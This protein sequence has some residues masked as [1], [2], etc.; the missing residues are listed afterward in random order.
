MAALF[1]VGAA[2]T[3]SVVIRQTLVQ[4]HTPD[5]MRGRVFAVNSMFTITSNQ[6]GDFPR[7]QPPPRCSG[8]IPAVLIGGLQHHRDGPDFDR[9]FSRALARRGLPAGRA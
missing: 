6:L 4:L 7:R 5:E 2:D 9:D 8:T 3:I 1:V